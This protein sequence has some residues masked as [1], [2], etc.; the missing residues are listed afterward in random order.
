MPA[1]GGE[2]NKMSPEKLTGNVFSPKVMSGMK[3]YQTVMGR[4]PE[5]RRQP[6]KTDFARTPTLSQSLGAIFG[7]GAVVA[8]ATD[9]ELLKIVRLQRR[10]RQ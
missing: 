1:N 10:H 9:A 7:W 4:R 6:F 2:M 3:P 5:S 8:T